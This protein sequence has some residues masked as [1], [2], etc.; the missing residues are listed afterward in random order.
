MHGSRGHHVKL[1]TERQ[2]LRDL[3]YMWKE[4]KNNTGFP[5][6][7]RIVAT[8]GSGGQEEQRQRNECNQYQSRV[9]HEG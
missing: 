3:F 4:K 2:M 5:E 8:G 7:E 6:V 1:D 9:H